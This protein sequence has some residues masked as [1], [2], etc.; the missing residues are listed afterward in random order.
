MLEFSPHSLMDLQPV[1]GWFLWC[2]LFHSL[3]WISVCETG[4]GSSELGVKGH[5]SKARQGKARRGWFLYLLTAVSSS[6]MTPDSP[7][8]IF[9]VDVL[10]WDQLTKVHSLFAFN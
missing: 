2:T 7:E 8:L 3:I 9:F 1:S 5:S 4:P 10:I 6:L